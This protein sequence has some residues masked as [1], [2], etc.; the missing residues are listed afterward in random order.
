MIKESPL[1]Q[2][3]WNKGRLEDCPIIDMHGHM[4]PWPAIYFP[5]AEP[6]QMLRRWTMRGC[7]RW[8]SRPTRRV[9][10]HDGQRLHGA[11]GAALAQA[12]SRHDGDQ[13]Q[14]HGHRGAGYRAVR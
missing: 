13:R 1:A 4:G 8:F 5:R 7:G 9:Q 14:L 6:E 11:R 3:Y 10:R 2:A 12:V